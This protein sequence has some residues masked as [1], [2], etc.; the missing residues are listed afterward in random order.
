MR[1][2]EDGFTAEQFHKLCDRKG[3]TLTVIRSGETGSID[4]DYVFGGFTTQSW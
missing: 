1:G 4:K 2:T 3:P